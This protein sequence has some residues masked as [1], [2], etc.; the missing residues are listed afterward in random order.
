MALKNNFLAA[1]N[2]SI[3]ARQCM[4]IL[5]F[6]NLKGIGV[7]YCVIDCTNALVYGPYQ[8]LNEAR[9]QANNLPAWEIINGNGDLIYWSREFSLAQDDTANP[10]T[11]THG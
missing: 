1:F 10:K 2:K 3:V 5:I 8:M 4:Q 7:E 6:K 11:G 9:A